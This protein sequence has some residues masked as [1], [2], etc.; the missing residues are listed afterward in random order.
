[1]MIGMIKTDP[2]YDREERYHSE[3]SEVDETI[4][5]IKEE[6]T[7]PFNACM[8]NCT[9]KDPSCKGECRSQ[10][11]ECIGR[12]KC[13]KECDKQFKRCIRPCDNSPCINL[14]TAFLDI[15]QTS[16]DQASSVA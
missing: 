3:A 4:G 11:K 15:C 6:C 10:L 7:E 9:E 16:C 5:C 1:M 2:E 14:C 13:L 12:C 8:K